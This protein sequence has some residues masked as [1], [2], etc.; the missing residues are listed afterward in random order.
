MAL[1]W[2]RSSLILG[3]LI[4]ALV[5]SFQNCGQTF[6]VHQTSQ[7]DSPSRVT[8]FEN[9]RTPGNISQFD[10]R[11]VAQAGRYILNSTIFYMND[12][13][14]YCTYRNWQEYL[15]SGGDPKL[16]GVTRVTALPAG[17]QDGG[18]CQIPLPA[19]PFG[20]GVY[21][22][23][24]PAGSSSERRN[25]AHEQLSK[26]ALLSGIGGYVRLWC[27][28][29]KAPT[30]PYEDGPSEC[31]KAVQEAHD[32]YLVPVVVMQDMVYSDD[33]TLSSA[34]GAKDFS[35][36]S[37]KMKSLVS[38]LPTPN[39]RAVWIEMSNE[40]NFTDWWG[41]FNCS[42]IVRAHEVA[43]QTFQ[44]ITKIRELNNPLIRILGP[45]LSPYGD[46]DSTKK[47]PNGLCFGRRGALGLRS[48]GFV[49]E[50]KNAVPGL[51]GPTPMYD[52]WNTHA[53]PEG[54][55]FG[56]CGGTGQQPCPATALQYGVTAYRYE[57]QAAGL[58]SNFPVI[59]TEAGYPSTDYVGAQ[60]L[61]AVDTKGTWSGA[62]PDVWLKPGRYNN[63]LGVM[64][65]IL[66]TPETTA[67]NWLEPADSINPI[68]SW[69]RA[70]AV[71]K[72][73]Y[74]YRVSTGH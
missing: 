27:H 31:A 7:G 18:I 57:M 22:T 63:V 71:F 19:N 73:T 74:N 70:S 39:G 25:N 36:F 55:Q 32:L 60:F 13:R 42:S 38:Q 64:G 52:A 43:R 49:K 40:P 45:S 62:Y 68:F 21:Y 16:N 23:S 2:W 51:F 58:P 59:I 4:T 9:V 3:L 66:S 69:N 29:E 11:E 35:S 10:L 14:I 34:D 56:L 67:Y 33:S 8:A 26:A 17:A 28:L 48:D 24:I 54:A 20:I 44:T 6:E 15:M 5:L 65:F 53:Y 72:S 61:A 41:T 37:L 30:P 46:F 12:K 50:M 1:S 47:N